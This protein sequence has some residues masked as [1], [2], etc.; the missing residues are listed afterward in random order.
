MHVLFSFFQEMKDLFVETIKLTLGSDRFTE[1]TEDNYK[2]LYLF[3][4]DE[5]DKHL[6]D[7]EVTSNI[8][9]DTTVKEEEISVKQ[10]DIQINSE[11]DGFVVTV[12]EQE[13]EG[14]INHNFE[15]E[16]GS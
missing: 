9:G 13:K 16:R 4:Q 3:V 7:V 6:P 2:L 11:T 1:V 5:M 12:T 10:D 8:A 15:E 14:E